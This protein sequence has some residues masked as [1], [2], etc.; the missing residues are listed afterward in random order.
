ME[1]CIPLLIKAETLTYFPFTPD[2]N[3]LQQNILEQ[4]ASVN[5]PAVGIVGV[6]GNATFGV[7]FLGDLAAIVVFV[8][9]HIAIAVDGFGALIGVVPFKWPIGLPGPKKSS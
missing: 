7:S 9:Q 1:A 8:L 6:A 2:N 5:Q 3:Y 4:V